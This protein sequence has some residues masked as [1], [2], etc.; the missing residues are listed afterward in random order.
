MTDGPIGLQL[1]IVFLLILINAFFA[2]SEI[3][4]HDEKNHG[5]R[6]RAGTYRIPAV[7]GSG[8]AGVRFAAMMFRRGLRQNL[9]EKSERDFYFSPCNNAASYCL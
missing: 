7:S 1:L 9:S 4:V 3:A 6:S 2:A 8:S 5:Y